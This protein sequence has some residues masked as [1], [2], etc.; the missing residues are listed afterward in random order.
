ME[1]ILVLTIV[2]VMMAMATPS[3]RGAW[4][5][6][7][8]DDAVSHFIAMCA[9]ARDMAIRDGRITRVQVWPGVGEYRMVRD[10]PDNPETPIPGERGR[11][12]RVPTG[13]VMAPPSLAVVTPPITIDFL[14]DGRS[15]PTTLFFAGDG[16]VR[17][18]TNRTFADAFHARPLLESDDVPIDL[19]VQR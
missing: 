1:L 11:I 4:A 10:L 14:P 16:R 15:T 9:Q 19:L 8:V 13:V 2:G 5:S 6:R 18:V 3:L 17:V 12:F 7:R